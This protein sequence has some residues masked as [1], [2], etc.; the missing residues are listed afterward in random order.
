[1]FVINGAVV[2]CWVAQIPFLQARFDLSNAALGMVILAHAIGAILATLVAG[3]A[4]ARYGSAPVLRIAAPACA[5]LLALPLLAPEPALTA[6]ALLALG[7]GSGA[8]DVSMNAQGVAVEQAGRRPIMSSLH[9]G[10]SLGGLLGS[11]AV[12]LA[13]AAGVEPR[14]QLLIAAAVLVPCVLA[15]VRRVGPGS[16][17][18]GAAAAAFVLPGRTVLVLAVLALLVMVM[19]GAMADWSGVYL[20]RELGAEA[21][22]AALGFGALSLGM[23]LGRLVGDRLNARL[24]P[25]AIVR[26]GALLAGGALALALLVAQPVLALLG[27]VA[28]GLGVANGVPVLFS[29]AGRARDGQA[30]PG[31]AAVSSLGSLGFL[32]GPPLIGLTADAVSLPAALAALCVAMGAV[33]LSASA[34]T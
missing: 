33:A 15:I 8:M 27:V 13:T 23:L 6:M 16:A 29:A 4:I 19:E 28:V 12:A 24:G 34:V 30:G 2:G 11:G 14:V 32:A 9:A 18:A 7:A 20:R 31:I 17:R 1:M 3:Q 10:W 22:L 26:G 21:S 5:A 25:V